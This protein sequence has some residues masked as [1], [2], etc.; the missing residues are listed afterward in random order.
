MRTE[1]LILVSVDD[2]V[3]EPPSLAEYLK[4]HVPA[5]YKERVPRVI[6]RDNGVRVYAVAT[7]HRPPG[8]D[9]GPVEHARVSGLIARVVDL[10]GPL[11]GEVFNTSVQNTTG[12]PALSLPAGRLPN[13]LPFGLQVTGPRFR[14]QLLLDLAD[15]WEQ[16]HPWPRS[17]GGYEPFDESLFGR[18]PEL[19]HL[20]IF[21]EGM[22]G[23]DRTAAAR[24][25]VTISNAAGLHAPEVAMN[26]GRVM[27]ASSTGERESLYDQLKR[28]IK[29]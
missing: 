25:G 13:G 22:E 6:R 10:Y 19:R 14:D 27:I 24:H 7:H 12:H 15:A 18:L 20:A 2:H 1:D 11:P 8:D 9:S 4:D 16:A 21:G 23:V 29:E 5:K 28:S 17:A 3:V 26:S